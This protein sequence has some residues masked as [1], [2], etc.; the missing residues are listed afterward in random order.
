MPTARPSSP[1]ICAALLG[2]AC[3]ACSRPQPVPS[4]DPPEPQATQLRDAI[5]A[6]SERAKAVQDTVDDAARQQRARID[7]AGG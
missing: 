7:A 2:L 6:P 3:S 4:D 5:Q 1:V